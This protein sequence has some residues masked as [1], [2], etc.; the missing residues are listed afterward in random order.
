MPED[1]VRVYYA[2]KPCVG[3]IS[4]WNVDRD[5]VLYFFAEPHNKKKFDET[6]VDTGKLLAF[7]TDDLTRYYVDSEKRLEYKIN[8]AGDLSA[9]Y[10]L[11]LESNNNI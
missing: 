9:I 3:E 8:A 5:T 4:G 2:I 7:H 6:H 11:P 1:T 10:Y